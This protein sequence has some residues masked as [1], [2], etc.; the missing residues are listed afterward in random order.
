MAVE[1][2]SMSPL[3]FFREKS[4]GETDGPWALKQA[5]IEPPATVH[6]WGFL[7][8]PGS[9]ISFSV[10]EGLTSSRVET[11]YLA[12]IIITTRSTSSGGVG[13]GGHESVHITT[14][15]HKHAQPRGF[16]YLHLL[17]VMRNHN[18][19]DRCDMRHERTKPKSVIGSHIRDH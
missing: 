5:A 7:S 6:M 1:S 16:W 17:A 19:T 15:E 3:W 11:S 13:I 9:K 2:D 18:S 10:R 8:N 12:Q 14:V 4:K